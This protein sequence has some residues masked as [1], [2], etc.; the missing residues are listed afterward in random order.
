MPRYALYILS[1]FVTIYIFCAAYELIFNKDIPGIQTV[2]KA[3]LSLMQPY[4][5]KAPIGS[6][7]YGNYGTPQELQIQSKNSRIVIAPG[8]Y[9]AASKNW[10]A[11]ISTG[12]I[13]IL[14]NPHDDQLGNAL[15]YMRSSWRTISNPEAI[16]IGDNVFIDTDRDWRYFYRVTEVRPKQA[17]MEFVASS[18]RASQLFLDF[19]GR[20]NDVNNVIVTAS[21]VSLQNVSR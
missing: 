16:T 2:D 8:M 5:D 12:H 14:G 6:L 7:T 21:L 20:T 10:L 1:A 9:D 11:R 15:V 19:S 18:A 13:V 4:I 3:N 17:G